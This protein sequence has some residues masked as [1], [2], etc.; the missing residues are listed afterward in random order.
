MSNKTEYF[1]YKGEYEVAM[2]IEARDEL[3]YR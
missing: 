2:Y 3:G 1:S